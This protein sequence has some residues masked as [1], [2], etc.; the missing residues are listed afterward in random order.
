MKMRIFPTLVEP[1]APEAVA[2]KSRPYVRVVIILLLV[3]FV[4][5][6]AMRWLGERNAQRSTVQPM[7]ATVSVQSSVPVVQSART[8]GTVSR[9]EYEHQRC[10]NLGYDGVQF[11]EKSYGYFVTCTE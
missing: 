8:V 3:L 4:A 7:P 1:V 5:V 2:T 6:P 9:Y 11:E 10:E